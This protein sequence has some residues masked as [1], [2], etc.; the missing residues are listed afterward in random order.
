MSSKL[1]YTAVVKSVQV[2]EEIYGKT[3]LFRKSYNLHICIE[4]PETILCASPKPT[5]LF[6]RGYLYHITFT[7][8]NSSVL[9]RRKYISHDKPFEGTVGEMF[10]GLF[11]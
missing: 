8:P 4:K 10:S 3:I 11:Q 9:V 6:G 7:I 2:N 5:E 1:S